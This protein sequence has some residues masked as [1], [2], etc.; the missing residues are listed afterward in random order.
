MSYLL[1]SL[2]LAA[3]SLGGPLNCWADYPVIVPSSEE[4]GLLGLRVCFAFCVRPV[5]TKGRFPLV[6]VELTLAR[7]DPGKLRHGRPGKPV[8]QPHSGGYPGLSSPVL[9]SLYSNPT[10]GG[11]D[12]PTL[13]LAFLQGTCLEH[14]RTLDF[15]V[16]VE[17]L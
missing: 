6:T 5:V 11:E 13:L 12:P 7:T 9:P 2:W 1:A 15:V 10:P 8:W 3:S 14:S 17:R 4:R 16:G